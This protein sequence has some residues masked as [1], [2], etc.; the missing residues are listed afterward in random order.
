MT[1][2]EEGGISTK[3]FICSR[4]DWAFHRELANFY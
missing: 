2:N 1:V 4:F 3:F